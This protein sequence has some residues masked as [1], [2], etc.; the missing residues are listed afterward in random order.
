MRRRMSSARPRPHP[1]LCLSSRCQRLVERSTAG[2]KVEPCRDERE[3]TGNPC[4]GATFA[5]GPY[6]FHVRRGVRGCE[7][8]Q[9][10]QAECSDDRGCGRRRA[11][12]G[13]PGR[14]PPGTLGYEG[15]RGP[16][17]WGSLD[18]GFAVR[19]NGRGAQR[20]PGGSRASAPAAT[21]GSAALRAAGAGLRPAPRP[22]EPRRGRPRTTE[23]FLSQRDPRW[24]SASRAG[25]V[26]GASGLFVVFCILNTLRVYVL[27]YV[28]YAIRPR[29]HPPAPDP[30]HAPQARR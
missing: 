2:E 10:V 11:A 23:W 15:T 20:H 12:V 7:R 17:H 25:R 24:G 4:L 13:R 21:R 19:S 5:L 28:R 6:S 3:I 30:P 27:Y 29:R 8:R 22:G 18:P 14:T 1:G 9:D 16:E 26:N